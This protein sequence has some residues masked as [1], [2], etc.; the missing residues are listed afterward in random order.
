MTLNASDLPPDD[1][2]VDNSSGNYG[3]DLPFVDHLKHWCSGF[4]SAKVHINAI[5]ACIV[6][7]AMWHVKT[8]GA[9]KTPVQEE[10]LL[11]N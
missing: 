9:M 6:F 10:K 4:G 2:P 3:F 11:M 1:A 5:Q 8:L 7:E